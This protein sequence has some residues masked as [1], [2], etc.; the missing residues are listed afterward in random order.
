MFTGGVEMRRNGVG[1]TLAFGGFGTAF[2]GDAI[3]SGGLFSTE[4]TASCITLCFGEFTAEI[5]IGFTS[6][7]D[8]NWLPLD[9][10]AAGDAA[11]P[12]AAGVDAGVV[13]ASSISSLLLSSTSF[14]CAFVS[15]F[16]MSLLSLADACGRRG[17]KIAAA[18]TR[19]RLDDI[20]YLSLLFAV[21]FQLLLH[22]SKS[23]NCTTK[24]N[25]S[26]KFHINPIFAPTTNQKLQSFSH[27][28][29][30]CDANNPTNCSMHKTKQNKTTIPPKLRLCTNERKKKLLHGK[31]Y[32]DKHETPETEQRKPIKLPTNSN[33][34]FSFS[35]SCFHFSKITYSLFGS[36]AHI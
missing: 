24:A 7:F 12:D 26:I 34:L 4:S 33:D 17:F 25:Y 23:E 35:R 10:I 8:S 21:S 32:S 6:G 30:K 3:K 19:G 18:L 20:F 15:V 27:K 1:T 13:G 16:T 29:N 36:F 9:G 31:T 5:G 14:V 2:D 22:T 28:R 11:A